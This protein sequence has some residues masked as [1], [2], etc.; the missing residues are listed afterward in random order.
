MWVFQGRRNYII[1]ALAVLFAVTGSVLTGL[2]KIDDTLH[3]NT[4]TAISSPITTAM[5]WTTT[6]YTNYSTATATG[7]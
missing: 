3:H 5:A 1:L 2:S 7:N 4:T 6:A